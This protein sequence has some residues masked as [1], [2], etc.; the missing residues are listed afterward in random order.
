[1]PKRRRIDWSVILPKQPPSPTWGAAPAPS[2]SV[3]LLL[4]LS[5]LFT[6]NDMDALLKRAVELALHPVGLVRAGLY[7]YDSQ[8]GL[9]L[10]TWGT[11]LQRKVIDERHSMFQLDQ[12]GLR[13]F[14]RALSGEAHWTV[15]ENCPIIVNNLD[16]TRVV[17]QGWVACTPIR[18]TQGPIGMLYNDAGLTDAQVDGRKQADAAMLCT[19]LGL[20][21]EALRGA[22]RVAYGPSARH[23]AVTAAVRMLTEDPSLR[24]GDIAKKIGV[25][26]SR[27]ARVFK[28]DMGL[29]LVDFRNQLRLDRFLSL[30]DTGGGNLLEAAYAAG[31]G[32]YSQFHRVFRALRGTSPRDY[33]SGGG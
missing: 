9:M 8:L 3:D 29:S 30:V 18:G 6:I 17:G 24:G 7:L 33:F 10:G 23:P 1:M 20:R 27:F 26:L 13:I 15:A 21:L 4:A 31:F 22:G 28:A 11:D 5:S 14:Q 32:S 12:A 25:S 2:D 19:V 16:E